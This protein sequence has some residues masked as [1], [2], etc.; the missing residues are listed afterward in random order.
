V[1]ENGSKLRQI[2]RSALCDCESLAS[3][4]IPASVEMIEDSAFKE[5]VWLEHCLICEDSAVLNLGRKAFAKCFSLR[6]F[7]SPRN[8]GEI[9]GNCFSKCNHLTRL[10]F[11]CG[12]SLT[13]IVGEGTLDE[14]LDRI[15]LSDI[16]STFKIEVDHGRLDFDFPG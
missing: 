11:W 7:K 15:G 14:A 3:I 6:S 8:V 4:A 2:C 13:T 5:C 1:F 12:E 16:P 9:G 10:K